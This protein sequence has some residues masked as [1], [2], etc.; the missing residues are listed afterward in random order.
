MA[1][2]PSLKS[3]ILFFNENIQSRDI[4]IAFDEIKTLYNHDQGNDIILF[5]NKDIL[6]DGKPIFPGNEDPDNQLKNRKA[7]RTVA[8]NYIYFFS[9]IYI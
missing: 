8:L 1:S 9:K 3:Y 2:I 4:L 7:D 6:V 5:N